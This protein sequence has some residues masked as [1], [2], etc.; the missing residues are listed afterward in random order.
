M[1]RR[2]LIIF[3]IFILFACKKTEYVTIVE[4]YNQKLVINNYCALGA[5]TAC[6]EWQKQVSRN[7]SSKYRCY[8]VPG[9]RWIHNSLTTIDYSAN[10]SNKTENYVMSNQI[11]RLLKD[12]TDS[13]YYPNLIT[14]MCGLND[15]AYGPSIIGNYDETFSIDM[16]NITAEEWF[17]NTKYKKI[18][19][20]VFGSARYV[21][22][23]IKR[24]FPNSIILLLTTQQC[25]NGSYIYNNIL[26]VN[27]AVVKIAKRYSIPIV[28]V[29]NESGIT[30]AGGL[31]SQ[32]LK[33]DGIHPNSEGE[34]LLANFLTN[35]IKLIYFNKN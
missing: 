29:F 28:D 27:E 31:I 12:K 34:K 14:I 3:S 35:K 22:E 8:A 24:N 5:S 13:T 15:S 1:K 30:D 9:T 2:L 26:A 10:G 21:I 19:E 32:Y 16:A 33:N 18:R 7:F 23:N 6:M 17:T 25:N 4:D 11:L 20:T